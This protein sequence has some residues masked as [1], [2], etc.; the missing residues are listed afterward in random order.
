MKYREL[1]QFEPIESVVQLRNA[2]RAEDARRLV[3]TYVVSDEMA[4]RLANLA[5]PHLQFDRPADNKGLLW[6]AT[7]APA[8]RI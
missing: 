3:E 1:I 8:S 2:N 6:S 7:T 4:E 5:I